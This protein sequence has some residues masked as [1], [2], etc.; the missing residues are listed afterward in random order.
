[1]AREGSHRTGPPPQPEYRNHLSD[2]G[3]LLIPK[4]TPK[5]RGCQLS[6]ANGV[7]DRFVA[8]VALDGAR[9]DAVIRQFVAAAVP[10]HVRVNF[11]VEARRGPRVPPW[12]G[13]RDLRMARR[14]R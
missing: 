12:P 5:A 8:Q 2:C 6:I 9:I 14:A 11:D 10:Q 1:M 13:N 4:Q 7:L 3:H